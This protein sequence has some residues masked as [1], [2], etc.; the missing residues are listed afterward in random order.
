M[1]KN[2][3]YEEMT[4]DGF[5]CMEGERLCLSKTQIL[6]EQYNDLTRKTLRKVIFALMLQDL[7]FNYLIMRQM[8]DC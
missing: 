6:N 4:G 8:H 1:E 2:Q 7:L 5:Q 3:S